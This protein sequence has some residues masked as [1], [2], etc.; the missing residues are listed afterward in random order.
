VVLW[1]GLMKLET[2][3]SQDAAFLLSVCVRKKL[4]LKKCA[5]LL[6][7]LCEFSLFDST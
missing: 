5:L 4:P 2:A 6:S 1:E 3:L 7:D